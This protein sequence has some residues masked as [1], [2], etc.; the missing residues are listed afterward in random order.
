MNKNNDEI[1]SDDDDDG[2]DDNAV[3]TSVRTND[4][5]SRNIKIKTEEEDHTAYV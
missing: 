4:E 2:D 1:Y 3:C 5:A